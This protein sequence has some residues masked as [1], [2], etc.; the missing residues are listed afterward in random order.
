M[1]LFLAGSLLLLLL[2]LLFS[3]QFSCTQLYAL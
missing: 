1:P 3:P 2:L